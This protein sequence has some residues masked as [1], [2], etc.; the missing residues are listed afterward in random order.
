VTITGTLRNNA[1]YWYHWSPDGSRIAYEVNSALPELYTAAPDGT[2]AMKLNPALPPSGGVHAFEWSPDSTKIAYTAIQDTS[3]YELYTIPA[4][5]PNASVRVTNLPGSD[6]IRVF[7]WAP[8]GSRIAYSTQAS[9][10]ELRTTLPDSFASDIAVAPNSFNPQFDEF[11]WAPDSSRLAYVA[12]NLFTTLPT[13]SGSHVSVSGTPV[14]G[15]GVG[16]GSAKWINS[17]KLIYYGYMEQVQVGD[18]WVTD[19]TTSANTLRISGPFAAP[20]MVHSFA[21]RP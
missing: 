1:L 15:G 5:T 10:F 21:L 12:T 4:T 9:A 16:L 14:A 17:G 11:L 7:H 20:N 8:N 19:A 6:G 13:G 2:A 3:K 18:V